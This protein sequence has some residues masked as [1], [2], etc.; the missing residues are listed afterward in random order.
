MKK[1]KPS[2]KTHTFNPMYDTKQAF[3]VKAEDVFNIYYAL[4]V[5]PQA[6]K[7]VVRQR[8]K[9]LALA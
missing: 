7:S 8:F 5:H 9:H 6:P 2:V 4:G 1:R 3:M